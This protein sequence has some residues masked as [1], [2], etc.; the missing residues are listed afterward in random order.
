M[1]LE[2]SVLGSIGSGPMVGQNMC[3]KSVTEAPHLMVG[4]GK[5]QPPVAFLQLGPTS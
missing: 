2:V 4:H 1:V 5:L 3:S